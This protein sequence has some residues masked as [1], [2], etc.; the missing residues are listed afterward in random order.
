MSTQTSVQI[1][2]N[3][4]HAIVSSLLTLE[5]ELQA[6]FPGRETVIRQLLLATLT[7]EHV[8]MFGRYGTGKSDLVASF[9][10]AFT[11][12]NLFRISLSKFMTESHTIGN[13]DF[14]VLR[15]SGQMVYPTDGLLAA[16]FIEFDEFFD[17]SDVLLRTLLGILNERQFLRGKQCETAQLHTAIAAT[18]ADPRQKQQGNDQLG[19][20]VDR[21][22]FIAPVKYLEKTEDRMAMYR[23]YRDGGKPTV[24]LDWKDVEYA[25]SVLFSSICTMSDEF[26]G[27]Y[28]AVLGDVL[29]TNTNTAEERER[30]PLSDR[31]RCKLL[32]VIQAAALLEQRIEVE[33]VD[34]LSAAYAIDPG[35]K[36]TQEIIDQFKTKGRPKIEAYIDSR[37]P[38]AAEMQRAL[39]QSLESQIPIVENDPQ[40]LIAARRALRT[41]EKTLKATIRA[42]LP[43][44][45]RIH[46]NLVDTVKARLAKID[47]LLDSQGEQ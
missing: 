22:L 30:Y 40:K 41:I 1:D 8:L 34:I 7:R 20:I 16:Q 45:V 46:Q 31:R 38:D 36:T 4:L 27:L 35:K 29:S 33:P 6:L 5:K 44:N 23:R 42:P 3:R 47:N 26:I 2:T 11:G 12:S 24:C 9:F 10:G 21:F 32:R 28:D 37:Q 17:A 13:P 14:K 18:N 19:A 39:L 43:T 25:S 15:D